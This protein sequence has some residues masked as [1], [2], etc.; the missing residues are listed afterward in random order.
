MAITTAMRNGL[1][2]STEQDVAMFGECMSSAVSLSALWEDVN[3]DPKIIVWDDEWEK[4]LEHRAA[5]IDEEGRA[6][7]LPWNAYKTLGLN[8][9]DG[10][11]Y[12]QVRGDC[13]SFGGKNSLKASNLTNALRTGRKP[14]EIAQSVAYGIARGNG[15]MAFGDGLNLNPMAKYS[16]ELGN[17]WAE[18]F[19]KYDGGAYCRKYQKGA[20]PDE[21]AKKTQSI[22]VFLPEATFDYCYMVTRAG[23]GINIGSGTFPGAS[24]LNKDDVAQVSSWSSG[25]HSVALVAAWEGKSGTPYVYL[26][27]SHPTKY[28]GDS[29]NTGHQWGCWCSEKD[30]NR[31]GKS[32][33]F[34]YGNW[35]VN[36]GELVKD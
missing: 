30:I 7:Y 17:Y 8:W 16:A 18:D 5:L 25:A 23:F 19:G 11:G 29:L 31:M 34:L 6:G 26:E 22:I 3:D 24:K 15:R 4:Y 28:A 35:Y 36:I 21:H 2:R 9:M 33:G 1:R 27:N 32:G 20:G 13:C 12:A 10:Y 14:K